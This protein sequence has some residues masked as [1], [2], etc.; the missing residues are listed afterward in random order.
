MSL[1]IIIGKPYNKVHLK[2]YSTVQLQLHTQVLFCQWYHAP[3]RVVPSEWYYSLSQVVSSDW[4]H[5]RPEIAPRM[6]GRATTSGW[7]YDCHA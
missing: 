7:K 2:A 3:S 5:T 1:Y 4:Y 6:T